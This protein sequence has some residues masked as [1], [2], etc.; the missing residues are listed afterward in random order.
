MENEKLDELIATAIQREEEAYDFY[1]GLLDRIRDEE[2][3]NVIT[4]IAEEEKKHR[5]FLVDYRE[6]KFGAAPLR[7]SEVVF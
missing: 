3:K 1:M 7:M 2:V 4:Y 5:Q 6:G